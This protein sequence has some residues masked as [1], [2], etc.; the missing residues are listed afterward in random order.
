M[1]E[2]IILRLGHPVSGAAVPT[3]MGPRALVPARCGV[4]RAAVEVS[5]S[6]VEPPRLEDGPGGLERV[7]TALDH[8][9][10]LR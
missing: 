10:E 2:H 9:A 7:F 8:L 4:R 6:P 3:L 5:R 1:P